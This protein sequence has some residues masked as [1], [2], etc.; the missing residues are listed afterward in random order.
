[1]VVGAIMQKESGSRKPKIPFL[2]SQ[3]VQILINDQET[4]ILNFNS[5]FTQVVKISMAD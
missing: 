2:Q 4:E 3:A 1:M 5:T